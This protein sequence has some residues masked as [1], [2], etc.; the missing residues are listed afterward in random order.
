MEIPVFLHDKLNNVPGNTGRLP[1]RHSSIN[2]L[3]SPAGSA[4]KLVT[5]ASM[6][7][8]NNLAAVQTFKPAGSA[9]K[10]GQAMTHTGC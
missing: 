3:S 2:K 10:T 9:G 7:Y 8:W 1:I 4:G 5:M 6:N